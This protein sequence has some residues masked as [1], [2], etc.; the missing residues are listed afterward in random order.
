MLQD[1]DVLGR[2]VVDQSLLAFIKC[3]VTTLP[4]WAVLRAL[5]A[6]TDRWSPAAE[7]ARAAR[8]STDAV[9]AVLLDLAREG[10]VSV[11]QHADGSVYRLSAAD[12]S[13]RVVA[14]LMAEVPRSL[15]LRRVILAQL[16][17]LDRMAGPA[18]HRAVETRN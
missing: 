7:I 13:G 12:P 15:A 17:D 16:V 10:V 18:R 14:R 11:E 9:G 6:S 5:A 8:T 3:H 1:P 2:V 4:R